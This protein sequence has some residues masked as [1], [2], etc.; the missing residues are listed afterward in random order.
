[1]NC[2]LLHHEIV[3]EIGRGGMGDV[4][5][6]RDTR[7][8]RTVAIKVCRRTVADERKRRFVQEA[9]AATALNHPNIVTVH[10]IN[11][12]VAGTSW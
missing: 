2:R 12:D 5:E 3:R 7:L 10:D 9:Q 8:D 6:A 4:Y 11:E 1:M